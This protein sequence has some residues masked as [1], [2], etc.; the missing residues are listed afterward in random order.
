MGGEVRDVTLL[1]SDLRGFTSMAVH[2]SPQDVLPILN[3]YLERMV[4]IIMRYRGTVDEF[5][6]DGILAFFG[7]PLAR[8]DDPERAIACAIEMQRAL[9]EFNIEQQRRHLPELA[10]GIGINTGEVIVGNIGSEKRTKYG[11]VGSAINTAYRIE[12]YTVGGQILISPP[13]YE[14]VEAVVGTRGTLEVQFKG[15]EKPVT[16]YDV[17]SL[18]G[19]YACALPDTAPLMFATLEVPVPVSCCLVEGKTVSTV[20]LPGHITRLAATAA[21]IELDGEIAPHMNVKL[22]LASPEAAEVSEIYGKVLERTAASE[23][24]SRTSACVALTSVPPEARAFLE[25]LRGTP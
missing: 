22:I 9:I 17:V 12:S 5:Q 16:L 25:Q 2:L 20:V 19:S 6:G 4:D 21:E 8:P 13:T 24:L 10:M 14:R 23:T 11:A 1:V 15:L 7:A 3:R 18:A